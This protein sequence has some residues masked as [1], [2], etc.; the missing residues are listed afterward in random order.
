MI[1]RNIRHNGNV[2]TDGRKRFQ[3]KTGNFH[4]GDVVVIQLLDARSERKPDVSA[5]DTLFPRRA[6]NLVQHCDGGRLSVRTCHRKEGRAQ[7]K[8]SQFGLPYDALARLTECHGQGVINGNAGAEHQHVAFGQ[9][10]GEGILPHADGAL[11]FQSAHV[12]FHSTAGNIVVEIGDSAAA[13]QKF[14]RR[15]AAFGHPRHQ[16]LLIFEI[17]CL[18]P[19][20]RTRGRSVPP[21]P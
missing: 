2:R 19:F 1:G 9:G 16:K 3:L 17:H 11:F 15:R 8:A 5:R 6:E 21:Q 20:T 10:G 4:H 13:Q 14:C 7:E 18:A 12:F